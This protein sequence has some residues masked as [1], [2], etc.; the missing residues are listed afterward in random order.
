M[1]TAVALGTFD[2]LH[3]AHRRVLSLPDRYKKIAVIFKVPPKM[4]FSGEMELLLSYE[5]KCL[6]LKEFGIDESKRIIPESIIFF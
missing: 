4:V 5:R 2:G 1:K 3:T 6:E